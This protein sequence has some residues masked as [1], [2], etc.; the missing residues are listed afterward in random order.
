MKKKN[1]SAFTLMEILIVVAILALIAAV[2]IPSIQNSLSE[3]STRIKETNTAS[4]DA[5]KEQW[6][7]LNN[8]PNGTSVSWDD[9]EDFMGLGINSLDDLEV[10]GDSISINDIGT[11]AS[12]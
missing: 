3:A 10:S 8:K 4:V 11:E 2:G 7:L 1:R 12:Y 9:I 5:A 6:A